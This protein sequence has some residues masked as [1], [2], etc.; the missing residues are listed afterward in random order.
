MTYKHGS[1]YSRISHRKS[2]PSATVF[3]NKS[4]RNIIAFKPS[5]LGEKPVRNFMVLG[6]VVW[7]LHT[8]E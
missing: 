1:A 4:T 3:T 7:K 8:G 5:L 6:V 2:Y